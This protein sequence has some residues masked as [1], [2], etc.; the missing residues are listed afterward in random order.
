MYREASFSYSSRQAGRGG[1]K[2]G[3]D[4]G[5][6][7]VGRL[8]GQQGQQVERPTGW[9]S[10][11]QVGDDV[12]ALLLQPHE[13]AGGVQ[14]TA[15]GQNH[16]AFAGHPVCRKTR[17]NVSDPEPAY[18]TCQPLQTA[19]SWPAPPSP[20]LGLGQ[21][22]PLDTPPAWGSEQAVHPSSGLDE[23]LFLPAATPLPPLPP[24]RGPDPAHGPTHHTG[25]WQREASLRTNPPPAGEDQG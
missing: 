18:P 23:E 25:A 1:G 24:P 19:P 3:L 22:Y 17:K 21:P 12:I 7:Q 9:A 5:Q 13:D 6:E 15:V 2:L 4:P 14:A 20:A 10:P 8:D 16:R 11:H